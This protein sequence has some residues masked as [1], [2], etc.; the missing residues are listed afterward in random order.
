MLNQLC[1]H[2]GGAKVAREQVDLVET[3]PVDGTYYPI[4][5]SLLLG[6]VEQTLSGAG[7]R[8]VDQ[9]HALWRNGARYFG[10]LEVRNGENADDYGLTVGIRN[11]HDRRFSASLAIGTRVFVC[12][13]LAFSG[14][15]TLA[16]KHTRF[17]VDDL[18]RVVAK[19]IAALTDQ[20]YTQDA[21]I[22]AYKSTELV[23]SQ[24]HDL[25]IR[26]IDAKAIPVSAVPDVLTEWRAPRHQEFVDAGRTAWR[27]FNAFTEA[28]KGL[29]APNLLKRS[30]ALHGLFDAQCSL[31]IAT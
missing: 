8:V 23:D 20:R 29:A 18:P 14:E 25:L 24:A 22:A 12:D 7:L 21:R 1:L 11:S 10:L 17:I 15:V 31:A 13:N 27:L 6:Q 3:P 19:S 2:T 30:Q 4:A 16:R 9:T 5:H 26:A 28:Y